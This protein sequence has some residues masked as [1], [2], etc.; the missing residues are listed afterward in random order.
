[1]LWTGVF[2]GARDCISNDVA[3]TCEYTEEQPLSRRRA[4]LL[5]ST[6]NQT[7]HTVTTH[8]DH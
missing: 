8:S 7:D 2:G 1:M 5:Q 3:L 6:G 4:Q